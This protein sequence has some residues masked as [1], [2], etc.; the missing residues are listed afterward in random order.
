MF[1]RRGGDRKEAKIPITFRFADLHAD[2][3][4][5]NI[6]GTGALFHFDQCRP[7]GPSALG[8]PVQF[9]SWVDVGALIRP[10]AVVTRFFEDADGK[11]LAVRFHEP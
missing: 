11:N 8:Q 9:T 1:D 6:S 5:I 2:A 4:R 3:L 10:H 7:I